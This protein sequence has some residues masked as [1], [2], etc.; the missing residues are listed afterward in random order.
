MTSP[1]LIAPWIQIDFLA[2]F[3]SFLALLLSAYTLYVSRSLT[4]RM[5]LLT[6]SQIRLS[7][8]EVIH[9]ILF[10][11]N[12]TL[13]DEPAL[14]NFFDNKRPTDYRSDKTQ[15]LQLEAFGYLLLNMLDLIHDYLHTFGGAVNEP[16]PA[17]W[18]PWSNYI[19]EV[20]RDSSIFRRMIN[21]SKVLDLYN[22]QFTKMLTD[23]LKKYN[24]V[25]SI[26]V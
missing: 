26:S 23:S 13:I 19:D 21:E 9:G 2:G 10:E 8:R 12:K 18:K 1:S 17:S 4:L 16:V 25:M 6:E 7:S 11:F 5:N 24:E 20:I 15:E 22:E 3:M 14:W